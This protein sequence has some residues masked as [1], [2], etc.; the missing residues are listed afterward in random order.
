MYMFTYKYNAI[1]IKNQILQQKDVTIT[2]K[3]TPRI[4]QI[5]STEN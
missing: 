1:I 4:G 3:V 2:E 5:I